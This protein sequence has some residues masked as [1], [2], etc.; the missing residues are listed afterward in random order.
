MNCKHRWEQKWPGTYECN[1]CK[2]YIHSEPNKF[3]TSNS[4]LT[5]TATK[6]NHM[7]TFHNKDQK[8]VGSF[9]FNGAEMHFEGDVSESGQ[10][11]VDW[12][13][14]AFKTRLDEEYQRGRKDAM[15][16]N[17]IS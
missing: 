17:D 16:S 11:F 2:K 4:N 5:F 6:P 9:D 10:I 13:A 8:K 12:V 3:I 7:L 15:N 1:K 14:N